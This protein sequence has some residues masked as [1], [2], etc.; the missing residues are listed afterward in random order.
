MDS[1][2]KGE[3]SESII[4]SEML[5]KELNVSIPFGE[6]TP[7][8]LIIDRNGELEKIQCKT[9]KLKEGVIR[10]N[11]VSTRSNF[12]ETSEKS[13]KGR[14]DKFMVYCPDLDSLFEIPEEEASKGKMKLRVK[15]PEN[16][17]TKGINW[18]EDYKL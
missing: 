6:N 4:I 15:E 18:A 5:K 3:I 13:Y 8:D 9:G 16:N 12:S 1:K 7:Y 2:R 11:T 14:I 17:Q 10:F